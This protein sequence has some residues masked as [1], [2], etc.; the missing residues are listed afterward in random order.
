MC[1]S[2]STILAHFFKLLSSLN[3]FLGLESVAV[4]GKWPS[5]AEAVSVLQI[6]L[7]PQRAY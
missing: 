2:F 4:F 3:L 5:V 1:S 6:V 7:Q